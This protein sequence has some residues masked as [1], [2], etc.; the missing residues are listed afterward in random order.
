M[1][2]QVVE[3]FR[4]KRQSKYEEDFYDAGE[5]QDAEIEVHPLD[6]EDAQAKLAKL[7]E[8]YYECRTLHADNRYEQSIDADF[9]DGL[10]WT[11][12]DILAL[13]ERGQAPLVFNKVGQHV[14]WIL[15]TEKRAKV[16]FKVYPRKDADQEAANSKTKLLKYVSDVNRTVFQRSRAFEDAVKV[17]VGW[18]E[19]GIRADPEDEPLFSRYVSWRNIWYDGLAKEKDL[20]DAR[21]IFRA[22]WVDQDIAEAMFP[23]RKY[24]IEQSA[25]TNDRFAMDQDED[26]QYSSIYTNQ[27]GSGDSTLSS[28]H[29]YLY[30]TFHVGMRRSRVQLIECWYRE[31]TRVSM[32]SLHQRRDMAPD[33]LEELESYRGAVYDPDDQGQQDL[34]QRGLASVYDAVKM[35]LR[36]AIFTARGLLQDMQ[37]PYKHNRFP[38]TPIWGYRRDRDNAPYGVIRNMRDPQEDLNKR[39]SKALYLLSTNQVIAD[40]DAVEDW[41]ELEEQ[42]AHPAGIIKKRR[43][44]ELEILRNDKLAAEHVQLM[45]HDEHFMEATSG[46]TDENLGA[47]T[48]AISGRAIQARQNQGSITTANLF[49]NLRLAVQLQG[50]IQLSLV[51]QFYDTP[52]ILRL[53][54]DRGGQVFERINFP[55]QAEDG[56]LSILNDITATKAD[57][58]VDTS[59][60]NETVRVMMFEQMMETIGQLDGQLALQI[61]DLVFDM[62]DLPGKDEM[63]RRIRKLNGQVDPDSEN[64]EEQLAQMEAAEQQRQAREQQAFDLQLRKDSAAAEKAE[65]DAA[66]KR[67][68]TILKGSDLSNLL[69]QFPELAP[70]IDVLFTRMQQQPQR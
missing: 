47:E 12:E 1:S 41:D 33:V 11:A 42:V 45:N 20:S 19:D 63:V 39:R 62:S 10:Q 64:H 53:I 4:T 22:K 34:I 65:A 44:S 55:E 31:P 66:A 36:C 6:S 30:D 14:N 58:I 18:L 52:K 68:E 70:A 3:N 23:E 50:E 7:L 25:V 38:F 15:G 61:L 26:L 54:D 2:R 21:Y 9:Y 48:N 56:T 57:F 35:K 60:W 67:M 17:G 49:D 27:Q 59:E 32:L 16:D 28:G 8:W 13:K 24:I 40:E 51:E 69:A 5:I 46:V 37:S 43:G 29:S